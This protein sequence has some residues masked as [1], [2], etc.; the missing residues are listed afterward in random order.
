M[1]IITIQV[2]L[3]WAKVRHMRPKSVSSISIDRLNSGNFG[4]F[5]H[6]VWNKNL[7]SWNFGAQKIIWNDSKHELISWELKMENQLFDSCVGVGVGGH[8]RANFYEK[9]T[10]FS[11]WLEKLFGLSY[12]TH[13]INQVLSIIISRSW[14]K[15]WSRTWFIAQSKLSKI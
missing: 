4:I 2:H 1:S 9:S 14:S 7:N 3:A 15:L 6:S 13:C 5:E 10:S 11:K 8:P 12:K